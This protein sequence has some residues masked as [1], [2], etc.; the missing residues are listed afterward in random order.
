M[1]VPSIAAI[2]TFAVALCAAPSAQAVVREIGVP[3]PFPLAGCPDDCQAVGQVSGFQQRIGD[4]THPFRSNRQGHVVAFTIRLGMP[5]AE[6]MQFFQNFFG[7]PPSARL[8]I[9]RPKK[10][11]HRYKLI[12][13]S[14]IFQLASYLGSAP[15]FALERRLKVLPRDLIGLTVPTWVPAFTVGLGER[16]A[17]R[18]SRPRSVCD[19]TT[20]EPSAQ[21]T[22]GS[23]RTYGCFYRD[24]RLL[25][26]ATFVP[27]PT[28]TTGQGEQRNR[29]TD[30]SGAPAGST[31]TRTGGARPH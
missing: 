18:S 27:T 30:G 25:Y 22:K 5:N 1:R 24:A 11:K 26:S 8:S 29:R 6:Q 17:W 15:S 12:R 16:Y 19:A 10:G 7:G 9:L 23:L 13:Q 2:V 28:P 31:D 4:F 20:A 3:E 14:E 21:Q